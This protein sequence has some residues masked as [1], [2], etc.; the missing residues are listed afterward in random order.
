SAYAQAVTARDAAQ[1]L[2]DQADVAR[3]ERDRLQQE[4]EA[5]MVAAQQA[6]DA[7]QAALAAQQANQ[8]T[9]EAQLAALQDATA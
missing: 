1:S 2:T 7:A 9:L 4:A 6:A 5:K 8:V 3:G